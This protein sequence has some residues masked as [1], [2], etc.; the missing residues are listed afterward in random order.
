[1]LLIV[2]GDSLFL[3]AW[4]RNPALLNTRSLPAL[5]AGFPTLALGVPVLPAL[6][7]GLLQGP[8]GTEQLFFYGGIR[9]VSTGS[10][11][12]QKCKYIYI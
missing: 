12:R 4:M 3:L 2:L 6:G 9:D 11:W 8:P 7:T 10:D 5:E 1:M